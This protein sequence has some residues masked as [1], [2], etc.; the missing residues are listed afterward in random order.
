MPS[1]LCAPGLEI[2]MEFIAAGGSRA[3][4]AALLLALAACDPIWAARVDI[5]DPAN[6]PV[7]DAM[8]QVSLR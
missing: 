4:R 8:A 1:K 2:P 3:M 5:R 6:H 7:E